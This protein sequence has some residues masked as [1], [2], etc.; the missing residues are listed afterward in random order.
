ME[1][2]A[3]PIRLNRVDKLIHEPSRLAIMTVLASCRT[4]DMVLLLK[5]TGLKK[6]N[7]LAHLAKLEEAEL[8]S[9]KQEMVDNKLRTLVSIS[10]KGGKTLMSYWSVL[11]RIRKQKFV[12][13]SASS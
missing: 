10:K 6:A 5:S 1:S 9:T 13:R 2:S 11:D 8:V 3:N 4:A 7:L 12:G